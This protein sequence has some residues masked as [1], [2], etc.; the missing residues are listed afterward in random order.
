MRSK[1]HSAY[2][3]VGIRKRQPTMLPTWRQSGADWH[4]NST[5]TDL[6]VGKTNASQHCISQHCQCFIEKNSEGSAGLWHKKELRSC[7]ACNAFLGGTWGSSSLRSMV[8]LPAFMFLQPVGLGL[9]S[10][11]R[12]PSC[13]VILG[14][15]RDPKWSRRFLLETTVFK[16]YVSFRDFNDQ[17]FFFLELYKMD[18]FAA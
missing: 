6:W 10:F 12:F 15:T 1:P 16:D 13:K 2:G 3:C 9:L 17:E 5:N 11:W 4:E 18:M 8:R 14:P 7:S